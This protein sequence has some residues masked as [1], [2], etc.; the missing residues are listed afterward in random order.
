MICMFKMTHYYFQM[1]FKILEICPEIYELDLVYF[2]SAP[3]LTFQAS[4]K[5]TGVKL[6]LL[7]NYDMIVMIEKGFRGE[8]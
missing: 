6:E 7:T 3:G 5:K 4:L 1:Y 2:V 8:I